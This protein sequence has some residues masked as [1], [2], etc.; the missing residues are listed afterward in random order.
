AR[1]GRRQPADACRDAERPAAIEIEAE[2]ALVDRLDRAIDALRGVVLDRDR[3]FEEREIYAVERRCRAKR[4]W[5]PDE[6]V[7][8]RAIRRPERAG[9]RLESHRTPAGAVTREALRIEAAREIEVRTKPAI[10]R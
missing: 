2:Q 10:A 6:H 7:A 3:G 8:R 4:R 5:Q 1:V 9:E